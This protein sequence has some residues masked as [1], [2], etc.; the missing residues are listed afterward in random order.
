MDDGSG[1]M[2]RLANLELVH[3]LPSKSPPCT[4]VVQTPSAASSSSGLLPLSVGVRIE[5]T[6]LQARPELN[7]HRGE[8]VA[9]VESEGR[10]QVCM[11]D[12][13]GKLLKQSSMRVVVP[14]AGSGV[15][16]TCAVSSSIAAPVSLAPA[17]R[18]QI[19]GLRAQPYLNGQLGTVVEWDDAEGRWRLL[20]DDGCGKMLR[21]AN[22]ELVTELPTTSL[23]CGSDS[24]TCSAVGSSSRPLSLSVGMRIEVTGLQALPELNGQQ[25]ELVEW[26]ESEERWRVRMDDGCGKLLKPSSMQAVLREAGPSIDPVSEAPESVPD[27]ASLVPASRVRIAGLKAQSHLN[28]QFGTLVEWDDADGRW[29]VRMN[30]GS[31]KMLRPANLD[32]VQIQSSTPRN[33]QRAGFTPG[34]R[35][36]VCDTSRPDLSGLLGTVVDFDPR[37]R[38]CKILMEDGSSELVDPVL[39]ELF[40]ASA[41]SMADTRSAEDISAHTALNQL[42][43]RGSA[44]LGTRVRVC[45]LLARRDLNGSCGYLDGWDGEQDRWR[46]VLEDGSGNMFRPGNLSLLA[47]DRLGS[48]ARPDV[49]R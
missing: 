41:P 9:W 16:P 11:D 28:G 14:E 6:G 38:L 36:S 26:V 25:G 1:K 18:V 44:A 17:S 34:S 15:L 4:V 33:V 23:Q 21:P 30:D 22:L 29:R 7:G 46:V 32:L 42:L 12:G 39:L 5:V 35:V 8:L 37:K 45:N 48:V 20:M 43:E 10:W 13:S 47:E 3:E 2:L 19:I 27:M 49:E 31:G 24:S 40:G